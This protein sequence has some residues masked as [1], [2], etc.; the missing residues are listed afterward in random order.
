MKRSAVLGALLVAVACCAFVPGCGYVT[1]LTDSQ[2]I[3]GTWENTSGMETLEFYSN[4]DFEDRAL[5][6]STRGTW[7][8][9]GDQRL[10]MEMPGIFYGKINGE[11]KYELNGDKLT[12]TSSNGWLKYEFRRKR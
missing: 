10:Q 1:A 2:L 8:M 9:P 4:G 3:V 12:L 7:K 11:W 5:L 6:G